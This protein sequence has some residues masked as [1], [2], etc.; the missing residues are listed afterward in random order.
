MQNNTG[1][2]PEGGC[3]WQIL[4]AKNELTP[5][6]NSTGNQRHRVIFMLK[7]S[8]KL[9]RLARIIISRPA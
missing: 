8:K 1:F 6:A 7:L 4:P 5:D 9:A 2:Y 3:C